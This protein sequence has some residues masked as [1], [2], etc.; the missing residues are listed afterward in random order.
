MSSAGASVVRTI[1][2]HATSARQAA[3]RKECKGLKMQCGYFSTNLKEK[4]ELQFEL[5][6]HFSGWLLQVA[7][8]I[9]PVKNLTC[10][11]NTSS[12][13]VP[14]RLSIHLVCIAF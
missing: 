5:L 6:H 9:A 14:L 2:H 7:K 13:C 3:R 12:S 11:R 4:P 8:A 10:P 1:V